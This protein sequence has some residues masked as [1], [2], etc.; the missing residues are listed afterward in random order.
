MYSLYQWKIN[1]DN[2]SFSCLYKISNLWNIKVLSIFWLIKTRICIPIV[3][4]SFII[5]Q[6][7]GFVRVQIHHLSKPEVIII[8][9]KGFS[10]DEKKKKLLNLKPKK[11]HS[12]P[13]F[14]ILTLKKFLYRPMGRFDIC[15]GGLKTQWQTQ[16]VQPWDYWLHITVDQHIVIKKMRYICLFVF[17]QNTV[18]TIQVLFDFLTDFQFKNCDLISISSMQYETKLEGIR[19]QHSH[20]YQFALLDFFSEG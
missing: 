16:R 12:A 20:F 11:S 6:N 18:C 19:I 10:E 3:C 4:F 15:F 7:I 14:R 1:H 8:T 5:I 13:G 17:H 9:E 2:A